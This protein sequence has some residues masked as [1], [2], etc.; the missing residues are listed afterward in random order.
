M[1]KSI[2]DAIRDSANDLYKAGIMTELTLRELD[3]LCSS[4]A[5]KIQWIVTDSKQ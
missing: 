1:D 4:C 2:L 3:A 5:H